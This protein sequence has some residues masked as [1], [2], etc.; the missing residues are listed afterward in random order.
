MK[1]LNLN[2]VGI[3]N[4]NI[5]HSFFCFPDWNKLLET[6]HFSKRELN[7]LLIF[8]NKKMNSRP[9]KWKLIGRRSNPFRKDW[10]DSVDQ[11]RSARRRSVGLRCACR[12]LSLQLESSKG[13]Y[14]HQR[15]LYLSTSK[16]SINIKGI[17]QH[18]HYHHHH[19]HH[20]KFWDLVTCIFIKFEI[21]R[22]QKMFSSLLNLKNTFSLLI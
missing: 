14:Q 13:I 18:H 11:P 8:G 21:T 3:V 6:Q 17:Y 9:F 1:S 7:R 15:Y 4:R 12:C 16:V 19:H 20:V 5:Y 2:N 22:M 10:R